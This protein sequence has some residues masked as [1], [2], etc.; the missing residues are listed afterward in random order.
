MNL[1]LK[2]WQIDKLFGD[3]KKLYGMQ[4]RRR[5]KLSSKLYFVSKLVVALLDFN[6]LPTKMVLKVLLLLLPKLPPLLNVFPSR[7]SAVYCIAALNQINSL[8]G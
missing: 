8:A 1:K 7:M 2:L 6:N 4:H 3:L 5:S